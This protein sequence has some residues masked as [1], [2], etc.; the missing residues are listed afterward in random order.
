MH[1]HKI[2]ECILIECVD[3]TGV[4]LYLKKIRVMCNTRNGRLSLQCKS[5]YNISMSKQ[6]GN[7]RY[8]AYYDQDGNPQK[9][10]LKIEGDKSV[11]ILDAEGT[12]LF[13]V[14]IV[15]SEGTPEYTYNNPHMRVWSIKGEAHISD[16]LVPT[17]PPEEE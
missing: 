17:V 2:A 8:I 15:N 9:R 4:F 7:V 6:A 13:V 14:K 5:I 11:A 12:A 3:D 16:Y 1:E 10:R